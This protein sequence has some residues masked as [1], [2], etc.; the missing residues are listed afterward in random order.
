MGTTYLRV[1]SLIAVQS[2]KHNEIIICHQREYI[3]IEWSS[4]NNKKNI[5][6][7]IF[8]LSIWSKILTLI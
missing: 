8:T 2:K 5:D 3:S 7:L 1:K 4:K 6:S